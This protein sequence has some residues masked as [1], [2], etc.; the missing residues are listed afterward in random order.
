MLICSIIAVACLGLIV[1]TALAEKTDYTKM[2]GYVDF[3]AMQIFGEVEATVEVFLKGSLL[4]M[5]RA[6][7][8]DEDPELE[9]MLANIHY[10]HVQVF[11][12][13]RSIDTEQVMAKT[14]EV[15]K[16]LDKRG[17]EI[18]VKVREDDEYVYVYLLPGKDDNIEGLVVM[19]V[20][21]DD[22]AAFVNIVGNINPENIG[23]I[24]RTFHM[25]SIDIDWDDIDHKHDDDKDEKQDKRDKRTNRRYQAIRDGTL[26]WRI[27]RR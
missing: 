16:Q 11:E 27:R 24:G 8:A 2:P 15:A 6:A 13:D 1:P 12:L 9:H 5:A 14:R 10:I 20:E 3:G 26:T 19:A 21:D 18:A 7:V 4:A 17:W 22:E 25:D 23:K